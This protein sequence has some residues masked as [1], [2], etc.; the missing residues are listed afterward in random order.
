MGL[1]R[2]VKRMREIA[3]VKM[4]YLDY[5]GSLKVA[6]RPRAMIKSDFPQSLSLA[7]EITKNDVVL[8]IGANVGGNSKELPKYAKFVYSFEPAP[9]CYKWLARN[10]RHIPNIKCYNAAVSDKTKRAQK[11][12]MQYGSGS[13]FNHDVFDW[14]AHIEVDVIGINDLPF[15]WNVGIFDC[16]GAEVPIL[17]ALKSFE[18]VDRLYVETHSIDG[19]STLPI[20]REI[21]QKHYQLSED[22]DIGGFRWVIAERR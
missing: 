1:G 6:F 12:N 20:V 17:R 10:T 21:L 15:K 18:T 13:L 9:S 14:M 11:F 22:T 16:E 8:E 19:Q 7:T 2:T 4:P 3:W 5:V